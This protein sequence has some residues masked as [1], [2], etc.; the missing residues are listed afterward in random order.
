MGVWMYQ[1][2]KDNIINPKALIARTKERLPKTIGY[3]VNYNS[4]S[5]IVLEITFSD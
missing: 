2:I 1:T 5:F 3:F 4:D